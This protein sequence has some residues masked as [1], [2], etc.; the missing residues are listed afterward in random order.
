[1]LRYT[2]IAGLVILHISGHTDGVTFEETS[3]LIL[4]PRIV[5]HYG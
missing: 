4:V 2:N 3:M 5:S 1:M